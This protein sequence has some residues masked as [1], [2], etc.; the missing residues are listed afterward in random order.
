[1]LP[2]RTVGRA[3]GAGLLGAAAWGGFWRR[4][5]A[6]GLAEEAGEPHRADTAD[7]WRLSLR[8][9]RPTSATA[10]APV[11]LVPG[12]ACNR[13]CFDLGPER[14]LARWL[15]AA[16]FDTW[17]VELR[18]HG[19]SLRPDGPV[20]SWDLDDH[21][22]LDLVAALDRLRAT[23]GCPRA[24]LVGHSMGGL[25]G[26]AALGVGL[27]PRLASL[28][29]IAAG[30]D[31]GQGPSALPRLLGLARAASHAPAVP[32]GPAALLAA[33]LLGHVD[34]PVA[35]WS[36]PLGAIEPPLLRR[37]HA[38]GFHTVSSRVVRQLTTALEPGGVRARSGVPFGLGLRPGPV[39]VLTLA[40]TEDRPCPP[41]I[42]AEAAARVGG[43]S[44]ILD[45][46]GHFDLLLGHRAEAEVFPRLA[47]FLAEAD[48]TDG[49][50][51]DAPRR[52]GGRSEV[53]GERGR[54]AQQARQRQHEDQD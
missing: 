47:A 48:A 42:A 13:R 32:L 39:P 44:V 35:R 24:H 3:L 34:G 33:P 30:L 36:A 16:G 6:R 20:R 2:P 45:G 4:Y 43:R 28:T 54:G 26:L 46:F 49:R 12:L 52:T 25:L 22:E 14:S 11:L 15:A 53:E 9:Y 18:G 50:R 27:G 21:L 37:L 8:R 1:V 40:G 19:E 29:A 17:I 31:Y 38:T 5:Y 10:L 41:P 7:G 23:T 51:T